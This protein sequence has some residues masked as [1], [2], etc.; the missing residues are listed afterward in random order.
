MLKKMSFVPKCM[1]SNKKPHCNWKNN[2]TSYIMDKQVIMRQKHV[3]K[4]KDE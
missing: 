1:L 3:Y 4:Q 2:F